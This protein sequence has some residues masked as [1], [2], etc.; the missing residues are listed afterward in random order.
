MPE[1]CNRTPRSTTATAAAATRQPQAF[2]FDPYNR[3]CAKKFLPLTDASVPASCHVV[4]LSPTSTATAAWDETSCVASFCGNSSFATSMPPSPAMSVS[5][6]ASF[7]FPATLPLFAVDG[8]PSLSEGSATPRTTVGGRP[9]GHAAALSHAVSF[10]PHPSTAS[11]PLSAVDKTGLARVFL[12][13]LPFLFTD[14]QLTHAIAVAT[15]GPTLLRIERIVNWRNN[16]APTGCAHGF[17]LPAHQQAVL[18][19]HQRVLF[20]EEGVWV[21]HR[22]SEVAALAAHAL[23]LKGSAATGGMAPASGN[24]MPTGLMSVEPAKSTYVRDEAFAV[25]SFVVPKGARTARRAVGCRPP[26]M[27]S[28]PAAPAMF[29]GTAP[30]FFTGILPRFYQ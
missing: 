28:E 9:A 25:A 21:G 10:F 17:C 8:A 16:R 27:A 6:A 3:H 13:Q 4:A 7:T 11:Q 15:G 18:S 2:R 20:D 23:R 14:A 1:D 26:S 22:P 12:G 29:S 19:A 5:P 24:K 30:A